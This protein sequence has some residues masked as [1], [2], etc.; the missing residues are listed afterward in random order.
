MADMTDATVDLLNALLDSADVQTIGVA[1]WW[2]RA[3][4]ALETAAA[5]GESAAHAVTIAA[6]K[7]Q[8]ETLTRDASETVARV[9][10]LIDADYPGWSETVAREAVYIVAL[11]R[12]SREERKTAAKAAREAKKTP[13]ATTER[14]M[15]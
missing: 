3:A 13:A 14:P 4:T 6:R 10:P 12:V 7:L 5:G 9:A 2:P 1:N 11:A 15:F 8:I